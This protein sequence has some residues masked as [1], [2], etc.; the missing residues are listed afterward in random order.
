LEVLLFKKLNSSPLKNG[1]F[2]KKTEH[3]KHSA[4]GK[5]DYNI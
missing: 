5:S 3:G 2:A 1:F 4:L